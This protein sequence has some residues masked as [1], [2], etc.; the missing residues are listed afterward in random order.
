MSS[1]MP[2]PLA[3]TTI[4]QILL[5][6]RNLLLDAAAGPVVPPAGASAPAALQ[7]VR[8][9]GRGQANGVQVGT[10]GWIPGSTGFPFAILGATRKTATYPESG[11]VWE[12]WTGILKLGLTTYYDGAEDL[13]DWAASWEAELQQWFPFNARIGLNSGSFGDLMWTYQGGEI[14]VPWTEHR[15][16]SY[17]CI[18]LLSIRNVLTVPWNPGIAGYT[19]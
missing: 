13:F 10:E 19:P 17:G 12:Q 15:I 4:S 9:Y 8:I 14:G 2:R 7:D 18:F 11:R 5:A 16:T 1:P 3:G 6:G